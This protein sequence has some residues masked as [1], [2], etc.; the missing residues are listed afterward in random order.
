[1]RPLSCARR[2][3]TRRSILGGLT[4]GLA[5]AAASRVAGAACGGNTPRQA[6]GPFYPRVIK[7][8]D[9]DLTHVAGGTGRAEGSVIEVVGQV[10]DAQCR[11]IA[12]AVVEVWQANAAGRYDHPADPT[13]RPLD[14]NFQS[15]ARLVA[16]RNGEYRFIT[17]KPGPYPLGFVSDGAD[18]WRTPHIHFKIHGA[19]GQKLT[20]QMYF[21]GEE[22]NETDIL[23]RDV[24]ISQRALLV[25]PFDSAS[26]TGLPRGRFDV[27]LA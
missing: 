2:A 6:T 18:A 7:E 1:M 23:L 17:V 26:A 10:R 25:V 8:A 3:L 21:A 24:P 15:Y 14:P 19:V 11:P 27:A 4:V 16:D 9:W 5:A 12:D 20:T 22:L 13:D